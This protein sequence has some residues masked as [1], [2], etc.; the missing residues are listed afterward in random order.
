MKKK[1]YTSPCCVFRSIESELI[2]AA[3]GN[4]YIPVN[5]TDT[6]NGFFSAKSF[7]SK[8]IWDDDVTSK[9]IWD[10]GD[11]AEGFE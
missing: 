9:S 4:V 5:G 7:T 1:S 6:Y 10:D 2:M 3:S 11:V 8:S